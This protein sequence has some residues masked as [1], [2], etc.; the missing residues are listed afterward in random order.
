MKSAI[1]EVERG[2]GHWFQKI[3]LPSKLALCF[4]NQY[5]QLLS[6]LNEWWKNKSQE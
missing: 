6:S 5:A 3:K 2:A 4:A 1:R